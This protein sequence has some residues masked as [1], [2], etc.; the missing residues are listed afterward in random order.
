MYIYMH[1]NP[2]DDELYQKDLIFQQKTG[3]YYRKVKSNK[4]S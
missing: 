4:I 2:I 1:K 3:I